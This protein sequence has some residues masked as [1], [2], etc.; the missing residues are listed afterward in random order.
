MPRDPGGRQLLPPRGG[1]TACEGDP[2]HG[3]EAAGRLGSME[4]GLV[5]GVQG[6]GR[7]WGWG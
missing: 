7:Q 6:W 1:P 3:G 5:Q 2:G 4:P